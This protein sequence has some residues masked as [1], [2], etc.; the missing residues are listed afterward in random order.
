M[1]YIVYC[2][3]RWIHKWMNRQILFYFIFIFKYA[4]SIFFY[5]TWDIQFF[6]WGICIPSNIIHLLVLW[7]FGFFLLSNSNSNEKKKNTKHN[8]QVFYY[9]TLISK[10]AFPQ[11]L[12]FGTQNKNSN[13]MLVYP[14]LDHKEYRFFFPRPNYNNV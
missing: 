7:C 13:L 4:W 6:R 8:L 1:Y 2:C 11:G 9:L 5:S 12:G 10:E 14:V 3:V